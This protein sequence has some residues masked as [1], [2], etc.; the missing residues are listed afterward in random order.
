M[1][2]MLVIPG[3]TLSTCRCSAVYMATYFGTSGRGP[4]MLMSPMNTFHNCGSSST[5]VLRNT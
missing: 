4:T 2:A 1:L 3:R 5:L